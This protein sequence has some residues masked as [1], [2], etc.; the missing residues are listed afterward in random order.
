MSIQVALDLAVA[1]L[2][3]YQMG[4]EVSPLPLLEVQSLTRVTQGTL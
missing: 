3:P 4:R 1:S 2:G